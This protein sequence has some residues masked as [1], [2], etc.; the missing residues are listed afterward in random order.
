VTPI[1]Q[2]DESLPAYRDVLVVTF[3]K[4]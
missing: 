1:I 2:L 3:S 4:K